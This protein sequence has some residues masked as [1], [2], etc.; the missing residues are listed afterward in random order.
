MSLLFAAGGIGGFAF[1]PLISWLISG[2]GWRSTWICL[3]GIHLVLAVVL[4]GIL[5]RSKPEEL[6]QLPD[7]EITETPAE[8]GAGSTVV[9]RV[10]QTAVDWKVRD[11]LRTPALWLILIFSAAAMSTL[12]FL[13]IHQVAYLLDLGF[14]HLQS[15]TALGFLVGMSIIG[16][17]ACGALGTRFEGRHLATVCLALLAAGI[18]I[19]IKA[20]TLPLV[21]LHAILSGIGYGGLIVL[22]PVLFGAYFGRTYF[23]QIVGWTAPV[24]TIV[25]AVSPLLAAFIYDISGSYLPT[26][27]G[28]VAFLVVGLICA[29]LARPPKPPTTAL[30]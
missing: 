19:L 10:Y 11:A 2:L 23:A 3:A 7:G 14:S 9:R 25:C 21:Y 24:M 4:G 29:P 18:L 12:S 13:M 1:P 27:W 6:G 5:I 22:Q 26:F 28:A 17:L 8:A 30:P 15:S 20:N 16:R